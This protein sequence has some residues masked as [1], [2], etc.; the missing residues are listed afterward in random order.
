MGQHLFEVNMEHLKDHADYKYNKSRKINTKYSV[1]GKRNT[2]HDLINAGFEPLETE[3]TVE[4]E[5]EKVD[6]DH[7]LLWDL[8]HTDE[9]KRFFNEKK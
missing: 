2:M 7:E 3:D 9:L 6:R 4:L 8:H 5:S 1:I